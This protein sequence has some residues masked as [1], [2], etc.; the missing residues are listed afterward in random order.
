MNTPPE[1]VE[2]VP[3]P[4]VNTE[5]VPPPAVNTI[6]VKTSFD[7]PSPSNVKSGVDFVCQSDCVGLLESQRSAHLC[8]TLRSDLMD[9]LF[10]SNDSDDAAQSPKTNNTN[11]LHIAN[12]DH[13]GSA[14]EEH[15][16]NDKVRNAHVNSLFD[17]QASNTSIN[18]CNEK[19]LSYKNSIK[20]EQSA[21]S[22]DQVLLI[23]KLLKESPTVDGKHYSQNTI[24]KIKNCEPNKLPSTESNTLAKYLESF[25]PCVN[26]SLT[27]QSENQSSSV[28]KSTAKD[29]STVTS[30]KA[31]TDQITAKETTDDHKGNLPES[32]SNSSDSSHS[33]CSSCE[34]ESSSSDNSSIEEA[35]KPD[36]P[37]DAPK[38]ILED[39]ISTAANVKEQNQILGNSFTSADGMRDTNPFFTTS[40]A[41]SYPTGDKTALFP[42]GFA[43]AS[44][45]KKHVFGELPSKEK[46]LAP[47]L[48]RDNSSS[49]MRNFCERFKLLSLKETTQFRY[50]QSKL[51]TINHTPFH[52]TLPVFNKPLTSGSNILGNNLIKPSKMTLPFVKPQ[53]QSLFSTNLRAFSSSANVQKHFWFCRREAICC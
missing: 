33:S 22:S 50:K 10:L 24:D 27:K 30:D 28:L 48:E 19:S 35:E 12:E 5:S 20:R 23:E 26:S 36:Q 15:T 51:S 41:L 1:Y 37:I 32:S 3:P 8:S 31:K 18:N 6:D 34:D 13:K 9:D 52:Q 39:S 53:K 25:S 43:C 11:P 2:S 49:V 29:L 38:E 40:K 21:I 17:A 16:L 4:A 14:R 42:T 47:K 46:L 7:R 45:P 44:S